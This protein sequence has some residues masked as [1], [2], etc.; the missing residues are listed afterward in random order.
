[1]IMSSSSAHALAYTLAGPLEITGSETGNVNGVIGTLLPVS[2][3]AALG[4]AISASTGNIS[5]V[6]NDVV[7]FSLVLSPSSLASVDQIG[8]GAASSPIIP[9]PVGAGVF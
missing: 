7:V 9:N 5:F 3:P 4:D 2:L 8:I 1:M 6:T